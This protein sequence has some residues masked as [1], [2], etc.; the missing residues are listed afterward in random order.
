MARQPG[1]A[2]IIGAGG[3]V[4]AIVAALQDA[5]VAEIRLA[6]RTRARAEAL[7]ADLGGVTVVDWA[8]RG[9]ALAGAALLVNGTTQ[10]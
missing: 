6:N 4:R 2:T 8:D 9:A 1:P 7:A 5:G 3:A 10:G